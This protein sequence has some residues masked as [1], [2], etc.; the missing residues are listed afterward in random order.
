MRVLAIGDIVGESGAYDIHPLKS[1]LPVHIIHAP[2]E[3]KG[4]SHHPGLTGVLA[5][6]QC[7]IQTAQQ[8]KGFGEE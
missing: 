5:Q 1:I 3:S 7:P 8:G 6:A 4:G 2:Y